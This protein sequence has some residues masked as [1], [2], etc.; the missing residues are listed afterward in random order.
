MN[1]PTQEKR[2][3]FVFYF[4][5]TTSI[6][7]LLVVLLLVGFQTYVRW[8]VNQNFTLVGGNELEVLT[9]SMSAL[10]LAIASIHRP[11]KNAE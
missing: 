9:V 6:L 3:R 2:E 11:S 10:V 4:S 1:T 8:F 5:V 7:L